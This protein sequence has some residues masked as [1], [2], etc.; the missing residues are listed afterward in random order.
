MEVQER[1][2][3]CFRDFRLDAR[4]RLLKNGE[5]SVPLPP[6]AF[7]LLLFLVRNAGRLVE[8]DVLLHQVWSGVHVEEGNL[9][10]H[11]SMLRKALDETSDGS[12]CIETIPKAGYRFV[13]AVS[14]LSSDGLAATVLEPRPLLSPDK[15]EQVKPRRWF[16]MQF[17][18]AGA[19]FFITIAALLAWTLAPAPTARVVRTDRLTRS[20]RASWA[21]RVLTDGVRLY[22]VERIGGRQAL[23]SAPIDGG[24]SIL[25]PTPFANSISL[26]DISPDHTKLLLSGDDR[27]EGDT[28]FWTIPVAGGSPKRLGVMG[29]DAAWFPDGRRIL[30]THGL[31][32]YSASEDGSEPRKISTVNGRPWGFHWSPDGRVLRFT[33]ENAQTQVVSIWEAAAD[34]THA[35]QW[36]GIHTP[37][38]PGWLQGEAGGVWTPDGR[39]FVYR[40]M[41]GTTTGLWAVREQTGLRGRFNNEPFLLYT[42]PG[43]LAYLNP[44]VSFD[45]KRIFFAAEQESRELVRY[46]QPTRRFISYLGGIPARMVDFSR[47]AKW[48]AYYTNDY[49]LW[50]SRV[51]GSDRLQLGF[52]SLA[53]GPPRWSPDG[54]RIAFRADSSGNFRIYLISPEGGT[55]QA[56]TP[57]EFNRASAPCWSP[58]G[59]SLIF[60]EMPPIPNTVPRPQHA[61]QRINLETGEVTALPG[62]E[63]LNAQDL[64]PDGQNIIAFTQNDSRLVLF[65]LASHRITE[66]ASGKS[67]YAAFWSHD[68]RYIYFQDLSAGAEQPISRMRLSDHKIEP[69]AG[70]SQFNPADAMAFSFA[71]LTSDGSPLASVILNRGDLYALNVDLP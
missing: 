35:H 5:R 19:L 41:R 9:A 45:G 28:T 50:R 21:Q 70:L 64:S 62:S 68:G 1:V 23:A 37:P 51:D 49:H 60:G 46:D 10:K 14:E 17:L 6:K 57:A 30:F 16:R 48:A 32:I 47:D 54:K 63:G 71:G 34:G 3:Y 13:A 4:E 31:D 29:N 12:A 33:V 25:V 58:D 53:A 43:G 44:L 18:F 20:S 67:F 61:M 69:I 39:Y 66:L 15:D 38:K 36:P 26:L 59:K 24:D 55:P 11:I 42:F 27:T 7:D 56:I 40:S 2:V 52:Q 22:F 8:K 65:N